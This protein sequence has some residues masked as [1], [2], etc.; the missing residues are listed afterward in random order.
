M[1]SEAEIRS[2]ILAQQTLVIFV[3]DELTKVAIVAACGRC[4]RPPREVLHEAVGDVYLF[5][6][7]PVEVMLREPKPH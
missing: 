1:I 7:R 6:Q 5:E 4:V 3:V 2:W